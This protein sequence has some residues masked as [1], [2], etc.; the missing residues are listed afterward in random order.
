MG[1]VDETHSCRFGN[2]PLCCRKSRLKRCRINAFA[3]KARYR[4]ID[5]VLGLGIKPAAKQRANEL[6]VSRFVEQRDFDELP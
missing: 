3:L 4:C 6:N 1:D 5:L 2:R